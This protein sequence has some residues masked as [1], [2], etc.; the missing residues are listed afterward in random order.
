[1]QFLENEFLRVAINEFGAELTSIVR[2]SD[3]SEYVWNAD[4]AFWGK[5]APL[6]FPIIGRLKD[7]EYTLDGTT[8]EITRHGF[9]RDK[10]FT[11]VQASDTCVELS[12]SAD[13]YT[14]AMYPYDFTFTIRYSLDGKTLKKEH[15]VQNDSNHTMYYE[16]GGHDAYMLSFDDAALSDYYLEFEGIDALDVIDCDADVM[17]MQSHHAVPLKDGRLYLSRETFSKDNTLMLDRLPVHRCTLGCLSHSQKVIMEFPEI[18]Y[19]A[20]WSPY[21]PD[22]DVPFICLEPWSTLP[23]CAY[24]GKELEKKVGIRTVAAGRS[25][26]L[27]FRVTIE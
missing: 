13:A 3:Q 7:Q 23:D 9:A 4:P 1:M 18:D 24:L 10:E 14:K 2:K 21:K 11:V 25:E 17:L 27:S 5:H 12:L 16:I 19:F 15:I 8:Y 6:L 22:C 26:T 20:V